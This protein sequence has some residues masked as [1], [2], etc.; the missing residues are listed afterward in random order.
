MA[1]DV[2]ADWTYNGHQQP[3]YD[4]VRAAARVALVAVF[5][6]HPSASVQHTLFAMGEAVID[7]C[8][9]VDTVRLRLPNKHH[10]PVDLAAFGLTNDRAV[11]VATDRP[12]GVIEAEVRRT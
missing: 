3:S 10:I 11:N 9:D 8:L 5:S 4:H 7:A 6:N 1:T 2:S 12:F